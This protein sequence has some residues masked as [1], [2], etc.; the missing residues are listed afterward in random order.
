MIIEC[1][2]QASKLAA[3]YQDG[4]LKIIQPFQKIIAFRGYLFLKLGPGSN[5]V[6]V[7]PSSHLLECSFIYADYTKIG[8]AINR[9]EIK[10]R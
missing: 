4:S 10:N 7:F 5:I 8:Y 6:S 9:C 1:V 3:R 2:I